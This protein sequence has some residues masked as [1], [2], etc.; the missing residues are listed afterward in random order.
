MPADAITLP[1]A[2]PCHAFISCQRRRFATP[3]CRFR[4][5][6]QLIAFRHCHFLSCHIFIIFFISPLAAI[7]TPP[8]FAIIFTPCFSL[9]AIDFLSLSATPF[10]CHLLLPLPP[11]ISLIIADIDAAMPAYFRL[12]IYAI[13]ITPLFSPLR[14][15]FSLRLYYWYLY[16][17]IDYCHYLLLIRHY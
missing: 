1:I 4:R 7:F 11:A 9:F 3:Y 14:H 8:L 12:L 2:Q 16:S 13:N 10:H 17:P 15:C 6:F 5:L